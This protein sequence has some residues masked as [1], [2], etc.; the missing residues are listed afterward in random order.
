MYL[1]RKGL[2]NGGGSHVFDMPFNSS[3][4]TL[5][6]AGVGL[7]EFDL[8][9]KQ[10]GSVSVDAMH[11]KFSHDM[12]LQFNGCSLESLILGKDIEDNVCDLCINW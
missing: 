3:G 7:N 8:I 5:H 9:I 12:K 10:S 1:G 11:E 6:K 2:I 4:E